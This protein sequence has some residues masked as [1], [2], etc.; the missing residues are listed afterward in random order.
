[1]SRQWASAVNPLARGHV[2]APIR[3]TQRR[4]EATETISYAF[5]AIASGP[6]SEREIILE[7]ELT[8]IGRGAH[9][10]IPIDEASASREHAAIV[11]DGGFFSLRD[12]G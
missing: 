3:V 6:S 10:D 9:V 11:R 8:V 4:C 2:P 5:L 12:L 1:M 7:K